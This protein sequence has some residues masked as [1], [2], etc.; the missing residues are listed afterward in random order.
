MTQE[1]YMGMHRLIWF[2]TRFLNLCEKEGVAG[3]QVPSE[4]R[5]EREE[6]EEEEAGEYIAKLCLDDDSRVGDV[7]E[8]NECFSSS[9]G[10]IT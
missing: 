5:G 2:G 7:L 4:E 9:I 10:T 3:V 1:R 6:K 8:L